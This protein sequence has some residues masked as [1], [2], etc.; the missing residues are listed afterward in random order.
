MLTARRLAG[1]GT[2]TRRLQ[3][4][5]ALC[6]LSIITGCSTTSLTREISLG[7]DQER[8]PANP[9]VTSV[10]LKIVIIPFEDERA[11]KDKSSLGEWTR[12]NGTK[13]TFISTKPLQGAIT[14]SLME[15]LEKAGLDAEIAASKRPEDFKTPPPD[16]I[17]YGRVMSFNVN[18]VSSL[19]RTD[20]RSD[21]R[22]KVF[23]RNVKDGSV[24][25]TGVESRSEPK[26]VATLY[27]DVF[28]ET[29]VGSLSDA[30]EHIFR[31]IAVKDGVL[32]VVR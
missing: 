23:I 15:Y 13:D 16:L 1:E 5:T 6:M 20:I 27:R 11:V 30:L 3:L 32:K 4:L 26:T 28:K 14:N 8:K 12:L 24:I 31:N 7:Y 17:I 9:L 22:L 19:G 21:I 10:P 2:V 18:A 29:L 25:A